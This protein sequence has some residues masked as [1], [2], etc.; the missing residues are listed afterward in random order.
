MGF[1]KVILHFVYLFMSWW[2]LG[3]LQHGGNSE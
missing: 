3:Y 1:L 2:V